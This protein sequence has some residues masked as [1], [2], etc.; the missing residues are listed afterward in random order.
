[1]VLWRTP[2]AS[3]SPGASASG[4]RP[5]RDRPAA[6]QRSD[7][8]ACR[9]TTNRGEG[10]LVARAHRFF[11]HHRARS[12][13]ACLGPSAVRAAWV[14]RGWC[15]CSRAPA[16]ARVSPAHPHRPSAWRSSLAG[17]TRAVRSCVDARSTSCPASRTP[18]MQTLRTASCGGWQSPYRPFRPR[19]SLSPCRHRVA[20]S[21][22][23]RSWRL[24]GISPAHRV[25][26]FGQD[27]RHARR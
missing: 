11:T 6:T 1:V 24:T 20:G 26:L 3:F 5:C 23:T 14:R 13:A 18:R 21:I 22:P 10:G 15:R 2:R 8:C 9:S 27:R 7:S 19:T 4:R 16:S 12:K 25:H 17:F